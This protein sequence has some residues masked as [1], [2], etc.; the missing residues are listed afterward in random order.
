[1]AQLGTSG[2]AQ[3][4]VLGQ[5]HCC[6]L[7]EECGNISGP[8]LAEVLGDIFPLVQSCIAC[9]GVFVGHAWL[10]ACTAAWVLRN[11]SAC[12][13]L[14]H[15]I[16]WSRWWSTGSHTLSCGLSPRWCCTL[17]PALWCRTSCTQSCMLACTWWCTRGYTGSPPVWSRRS[18]PLSCTACQTPWHTGSQNWF[19][20]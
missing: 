11:T 18:A 20:Q 3:L 14:H 15:G 13:T 4:Q 2:Q 8:E 19:P 10:L 6:T 1:M 5:E 7:A 17:C 16:H 12:H 9:W